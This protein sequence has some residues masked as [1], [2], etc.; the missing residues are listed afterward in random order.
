MGNKIGSWWLAEVDAL[1]GEQV[2]WD[3]LANRQQ[4][5]WRAVGG[6]L[7]LTN[8]RIIFCPHFLE[9]VLGGKKWSTPLDDITDATTE[10]P[11]GEP[12]S[13][14]LRPR[15]ALLLQDGSRELFVVN[16]LN[17]TV[18]RLQRALPRRR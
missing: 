3:C 5:G 6:K 9:R 15:L 18:P 1:S 10:A 7:Y 12:L 13:G 16:N 2:G 11:D 17:E 8:Q 14:G 4:D